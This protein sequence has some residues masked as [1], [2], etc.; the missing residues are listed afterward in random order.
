MNAW[1]QAQFSND[2]IFLP[3]S[4]KVFEVPAK[5]ASDSKGNRYGINDIPAGETKDV[6]HLLTDGTNYS[7]YNRP[8][9]QKYLRYNSTS[10]GF[11]IDQQG[12]GDFYVPSS[13][14][15]DTS[16][17]KHAYYIQV[18]S[19][20]KKVNG[21]TPDPGQGTSLETQAS[22]NFEGQ[23]ETV[24]QH[25]V[26]YISSSNGGGTDAKNIEQAVLIYVDDD[27]NENEIAKRSNTNGYSGDIINFGDSSQKTYDNLINKNYVY[28]C[29]T[30]GKDPIGQDPKSL[31]V[32]KNTKGDFEAFS[33]SNIYSTYDDTDNSIDP[34][35]DTQPQYFVVHFTHNKRTEK[36]TA[37]VTENINYIYE[38][39]PHAGRN[40][41]DDQTTP[42]SRTI[43]YTRTRD[44]D[45]VKDPDSSK[46]KW[47]KWIPD[48]SF[49]TSFSEEFSLPENVSGIDNKDKVYTIDSKNITATKN[50]TN[51]DP[52]SKKLP[53]N[54]SELKNGKTISFKVTVPYKLHENIIVHF[55][56]ENTDNE[57]ADKAISLKNQDPKSS[58]DNP[59]TETILGLLAQG[60]RVDFDATDNGQATSDLAK[61][62]KNFDLSKQN[63]KHDANKNSRTSSKLTFDSD[64]YPDNQNYFVYLYHGVRTEHQ[65]KAVKEHVSYYYENGPKKGQQVPDNFVPKDYEINFVRE[66]NVDLVTNTATAWSNWSLDSNKINSNNDGTSFK[67]ISFKDLYQNLDD[68]YQL[69]PDGN[70]IIKD[71]TGKNENDQLLIVKGANGEIKL[72][73]F[74]NDEI[75]NLPNGSS[76]NIQ[77]PYDVPTPQP[78]PNPK[79]P[80]SPTNPTTP[81]KPKQPTKPEQPSEPSTPDNPTQPVKHKKTKVHKQKDWSSNNTPHGTD[82]QRQKQHQDG[83]IPPHGNTISNTPNSTTRTAT[84]NLAKNYSHSHNPSSELPQTSQKKSSLGLIGLALAT[85]GLLGFGITKKKRG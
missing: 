73:S 17:S 26:N 51:F 13:N 68:N 54:T 2:Q 4:I 19:V 40:V 66:R 28:N 85:L 15:N 12:S 74:N 16:Y 10:S 42:I 53:F 18:D 70:F 45:L 41:V 24:Y 56:D 20:M 11:K 57:L 82:N 6:Y 47:S 1:F 64:E 83:I 79:Q 61:H 31:I 36:Q 7:K 35:K 39:G 44:V 77:V 30:I 52:S 34:T 46:T 33:S 69:N 8:D 38:N 3:S 37:T 75:T 81:E 58:I 63:F 72:I 59:T 25:K 67:A 55:I 80:V 62:L 9:F 78:G 22:Q 49:D 50:N 60:Y 27:K 14:G 21:Q 29:V 32:I 43:T 23:G 71:N 84:N 65:N 48:T 5:W 76:I